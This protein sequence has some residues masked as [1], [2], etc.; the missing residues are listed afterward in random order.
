MTIRYIDDLQLTGKR[1][2]I[3]VDFNVPLEGK[4]SHRR[5]P[6]PRGAAHHPARAGDGRQG[7][8][9]LAPGPPQGRRT[10]SCRSSPRPRAWPSC[11]AASTRCILA[12]DCVGDGVKKLVKDLKDGQVLLLENLRFHKEEE[13]NDE[14]F[15]RELA[16]LADVYV[17]DAFGTAHRA[18]ASTAGMV[19]FVK[20]KARGAAD[21]Q[22]ARVP[23]QA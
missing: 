13:A 18:H 20:E 16:A 1:V 6:H 9:R 12:D 8:P 19:P 21:A 10:R 23:R 5:H 2:F 11:S 17:N 3:R 4:R 15:A 14:A 7:D 22:G